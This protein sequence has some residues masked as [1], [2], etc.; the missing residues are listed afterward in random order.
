MY[1][2]VWNGIFWLRTYID[3]TKL[4]YF[5][6]SGCS[7]M[8][9]RMLLS[10]QYTFDRALRLHL[11]SAWHCTNRKNNNFYCVNTRKSWIT[12]KIS[13]PFLFLPT[14]THTRNSFLPFN[15]VASHP[16]IIHLSIRR[17]EK[18]II[19]KSISCSCTNSMV[20]NLLIV[21]DTYF[22]HLFVFNQMRLMLLLLSYYIV[23]TVVWFSKAHLM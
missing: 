8:F 11:P 17:K 21:I 10:D 13:C 9:S 15:F 14:H 12:M 4:L 19:L 7:T 3:W 20:L 23:D 2:L 18:K 1:L 5:A 16:K 6:S 22:D